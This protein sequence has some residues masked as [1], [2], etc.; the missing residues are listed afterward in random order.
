VRYDAPAKLFVPLRSA[1]LSSLAEG[2][3]AVVA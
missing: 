1:S 3:R 2:L